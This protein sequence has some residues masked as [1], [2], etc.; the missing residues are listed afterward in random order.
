MNFRTMVLALVRRGQSQME[1]MELVK[2]A[3][4]LVRRATVKVNV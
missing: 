4:N 3:M 1:R 2:S